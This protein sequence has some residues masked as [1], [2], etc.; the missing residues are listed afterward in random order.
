MSELPAGLGVVVAA[1]GLEAALVL[2]NAES[3]SLCVYD[4]DREVFRAPMARV[5]SPPIAG[6]RIKF[7]VPSSSA[8]K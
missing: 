6:T 2:P 1:K 4:G 3:A 8:I 5:I 7:C